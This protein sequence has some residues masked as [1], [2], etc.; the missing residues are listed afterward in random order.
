MGG[1]AKEGQTRG[2]VKR[3]VGDALSVPYLGRAIICL[4]VCLSRHGYS[5]SLEASV[6]Y[7]SYGYSY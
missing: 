2:W 7:S 4:S 1:E 3:G 6:A 5:P